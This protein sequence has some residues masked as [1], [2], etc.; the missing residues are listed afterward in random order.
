MMQNATLL[1]LLLAS[2]ALPAL[3]IFLLPS[4]FERLRNSINLFGVASKIL[5][6]ALIFY[7]VLNNQNYTLSF[8][9]LPHI[10]FML[11][12]DELSLLFATL[13]SLLWLLTTIYAI[14]YFKES[15]N[16]N[17]FFGFFSLCV[18]ATVGLSVAGNLFT[19]FIFYEFLTLTTFA[20]IL[21]TQ[22]IEAKRATIIYLAHTIIGGLFFLVALVMLQSLGGDMAFMSGGSLE[23]L[24]TASP[25]LLQ[26]IFILLLIGIGIKAA[27]FP[28][29]YW[30]PSAMAAPAPVS[31]LLHA[32]A[33]VKAG[34]FGMIRVVYDIYGVEFA[35]QLGLLD[36][37]LS[38][39]VITI[40]YGSF[41]ALRQRDIKKRLAYSTVSQV[42]Y[43]LLGIGL[44]GA[45]GTI[46]AMVH[47]VHQGVMKITLFFCAG[48]FAKL[49]NIKKIEQLDGLGA[50]MPY[51]ALAFS[52]ASLGMIGIPPTA[53]FISKYYLALGSIESENMWV[54][55]VLA[56]SSLL[57]AMYFLPL[58]YRIWFL[59][60]KESL[61]PYLEQRGVNL[62]L[63]LPLLLS[64]LFSLLLGIFAL[65]WWTP[66]NWAEMIVELEYKQ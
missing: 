12:V 37:L 40:L 41:M 11:K 5:F 34:A 19:F 51:T 39:A 16:Q 62:F 8:E 58:L 53:G 27:I 33:V 57:N 22:S 35:Q 52:I 9:F 61:T 25:L 1:I 30:L 17:R 28:L 65:A 15:K 45:A 24:S 66:L 21:H 6:V 7:G 43:I 31:A 38:V 14:A 20:L 49:Y 29:H 36:I 32:V 18:T 48:S 2:S 60:P 56:L 46:G 26:T 4:R 50:A 23:S 44:F 13:S 59:A 55:A 63:L 3:I 64:A 54:L 47:L 42:S 10:S